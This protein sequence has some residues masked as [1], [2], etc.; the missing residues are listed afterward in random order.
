MKKAEQLPIECI[1]SNFRKVLISNEDHFFSESQI[2]VSEDQRS[3][4]VGGYSHEMNT[5]EDCKRHKLN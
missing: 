3:P 1:F 5:V 2:C 4:R